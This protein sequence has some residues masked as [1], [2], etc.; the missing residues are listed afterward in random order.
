MKAIV[1]SEY[2]P[3]EKLEV[4][5]A[6]APQP[7]PGEIAVRNVAA[8]INPIDW[9]LRSGAMQKFWPLELPAILGRDAAGEVSAVGTGVTGFHVG[10]RVLGLVNH[11]YAEVV[12]APVAAWAEMPP[13]L[14]F[15]QAAALPLVAVT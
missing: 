11:A 7:G 8:S 2:G 14:D 9:K 3:P 6:P 10:Q 4:R 12:I 13:G 5:E 15:L 1:L